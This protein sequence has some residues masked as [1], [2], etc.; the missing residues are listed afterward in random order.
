MPLT[1][2]SEGCA[3][4]IWLEGGCEQDAAPDFRGQLSKGESRFIHPSPTEADVSVQT[5]LQDSLGRGAQRREE[6]S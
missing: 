2:P 1:Q 4:N 6:A 5:L 3:G